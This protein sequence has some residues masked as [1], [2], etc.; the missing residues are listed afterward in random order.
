MSLTPKAQVIERDFLKAR[1]S[2]NY[3]A[4]PE[5]VRR[6]V[7]HYSKGVVFANTAL[8]E[9]AV[10]EAELKERKALKWTPVASLDDTPSSIAHSPLIKPESIHDAVVKL[11]EVLAK[12]TEEH[13]E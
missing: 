13:Q 5:F 2:A 8:L 11:E 4:F 12:G 10:G 3:A 6:Y 7:K 1:A 9:M